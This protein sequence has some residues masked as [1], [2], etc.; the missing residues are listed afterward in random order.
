VV[1]L[2][3]QS[4]T[5]GSFDAQFDIPWVLISWGVIGLMSG[6]KAYGFKEAFEQ[7]F[8]IQK[9]KDDFEEILNSFPEAILIAEERKQEEAP[10]DQELSMD[11]A[12]RPLSNEANMNQRIALP[13]VKL[14]NEKFQKFNDS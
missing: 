5:F 12:V 7:K 14:A 2:E 11:S 9:Q 6:D 10:Q 13:E 3:E 1:R 4:E 8:F